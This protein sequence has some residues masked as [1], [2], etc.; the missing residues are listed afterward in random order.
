MQVTSNHAGGISAIAFIAAVIVSMAYYQFVYLPQVNA[1]PVV[2]EEVLNPPSIT[3]VSIVQGS[4]LPSQTQNFEPKEVT[5]N[6]GETN[7]IV[8]TNGDSTAHSVTTDTGY[9]DPS[10]GE[11][12]SMATIGLVLPKK[13]FEF[14][15]TE[16]GEY[17]Y[18]CE[19]H[20]WMTGKVTIARGRF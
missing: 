7:K 15:F 6:L 5:A 18:H 3:S 19:P 17:P 4:A 10:S 8:W 9:T 2:A 13:T 12:D 11:F 20:P 14:I 16:A 1:K